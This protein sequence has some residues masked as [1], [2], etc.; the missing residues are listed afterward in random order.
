MCRSRAPVAA[1][2]SCSRED[3][4]VSEIVVFSK[5][6]EYVDPTGHAWVRRGG[7][8]EGRALGR[9]I[10]KA[11]LE[12][13]HHY[14]GELHLVAFEDRERFWLRAERLM[15]ESPHADFVGSEFKDETGAH[16]LVVDEFC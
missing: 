4:P 16:L 12:V 5:L 9:R 1:R 13:V 10:R 7:T 15:A 2:P 14:M 11:D 6:K 3:L 8:L